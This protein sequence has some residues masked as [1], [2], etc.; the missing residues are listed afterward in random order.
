MQ[1]QIVALRTFSNKIKFLFFIS[2]KQMELER[3]Q[4]SIFHTVLACVQPPLSS[5][6]SERSVCDLPLIIVFRNNFA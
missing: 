6:K 4:V 3:D 5:K 1:E 2:F